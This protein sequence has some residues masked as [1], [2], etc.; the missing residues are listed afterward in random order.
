MMFGAEPEAPPPDHQVSLEGSSSE[1]LVGQAGRLVFQIQARADKKVNLKS[2]LRVELEG[3]AVRFDKSKL[4]VE[5][6]KGDERKLS[7]ETRFHLDEVGVAR[8]VVRALF[9]ICDDRS[10]DRR[11]ALLEHSVTA[12]A[13]AEGGPS[14]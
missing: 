2:P 1:V 11:T 12:R 13:P 5:D 8:I 4:Q 3:G 14:P 9:F 10:C 6:A 7:F